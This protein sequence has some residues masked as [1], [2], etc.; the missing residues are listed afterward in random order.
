M[1]GVAVAGKRQFHKV[2]V[3]VGS[4]RY[5]S[6]TRHS[7][8]VMS[9]ALGESKSIVEPCDVLAGA[10]AMVGAGALE[11]VWWR[12]DLGVFFD[13]CRVPPAATTGEH[14]AIWQQ[15]RD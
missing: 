14:A 6:Q 7:Y 15:H 2:L 1:Q 12:E 9:A 11:Q 8:L 13:W 4:V 5:R 3:P 10:L